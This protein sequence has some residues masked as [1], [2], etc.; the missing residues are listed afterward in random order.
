MHATLEKDVAVLA[1]DFRAL[2]EGVI[3]RAD[4]AGMFLQ[5]HEPQ[6][7][8][9]PGYRVVLYQVEDAGVLRIKLGYITE[10]E[11]EAAR[12][13]DISICKS[14]DRLAL[15]QSAGIRKVPCLLETAIHVMQDESFRMACDQYGQDDGRLRVLMVRGNW[16][17][18]VADMVQGVLADVTWEPYYNG[19]SPLPWNSVSGTQLCPL[20]QLTAVEPGLAEELLSG[21]L[22]CRL[23]GLVS[24]RFEVR[25]WS[26]Y[27]EARSELIRHIKFF[28]DA[29]PNQ[30]AEPDTDNGVF[31][32]V[33][34]AFVTREI[35]GVRVRVEFSF[36][37][38]AHM[39]EGVERAAAWREWLP[40]SAFTGEQLAAENPADLVPQGVLEAVAAL[41][42]ANFIF[43]G[44]DDRRIRRKSLF[45]A[46]FY[47]PQVGFVGIKASINWLAPAV[48]GAK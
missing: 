10:R 26:D 37:N 4:A 24:Q 31:W 3:T 33:T 18:Q 21:Q 32:A 29:F 11:L 34:Q 5:A 48:A 46:G 7:T 39:A 36:D 43:R 27:T 17:P 19:L 41:G 2:V 20:C 8:E 40:E 38:A 35:S 28:F 44:Q 30:S 9:T 13:P 25:A 15:L 47:K 23:H 42:Q 45:C 12:K 1:P 6:E 14:Y 16:H 22:F